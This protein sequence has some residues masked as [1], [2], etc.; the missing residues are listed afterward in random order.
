MLRL[1]IYI[2]FFWGF[3]LHLVSLDSQISTSR[4]SNLAT[5]AKIN[6]SCDFDFIFTYMRYLLIIFILYIITITY[7]MYE[8]KFNYFIISYKVFGSNAGVLE[9]PKLLTVI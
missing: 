1:E 5:I 4:S 6:L 9:T 7:I 3:Y 8:A 2:C